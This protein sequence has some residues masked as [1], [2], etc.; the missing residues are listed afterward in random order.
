MT[1]DEIKDSLKNLDIKFDLFTNEKSFY[2]NGKIDNLLNALTK[3]KLIYRKNGATWF[4]A[5]SL[6]K[7]QDRVYIKSS[8]EPTYRV[9]DT[10]YHIDKIERGYGK[11]AI[12]I[13]PS[14]V[15]LRD[16]MLKQSTF[17]S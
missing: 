1:L 15:C 16:S 14:R 2:K 6:G 11:E 3:K 5:S 10:A 7:E 8:G 12:Q 17:E 13:L 9:P 4:N